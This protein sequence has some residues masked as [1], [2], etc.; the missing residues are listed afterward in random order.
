MLTLM[1]FSRPNS[2]SSHP[3]RVLRHTLQYTPLISEEARPSFLSHVHG[4]HLFSLLNPNPSSP[5][6]FV[7]SQLGSLLNGDITF[8]VPVY[9]VYGP[10]EDVRVLEKFRTG[11]YEVK[12]LMVVDEAVTRLLDIGG[13]KLRLL[14]L[15]GSLQMAKMCK[16]R[17]AERD[18]SCLRNELN[19]ISTVT[20]IS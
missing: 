18:L 10:T 9:A 20:P 16:S 17:L 12:N 14:G 2:W 11:E 7:L 6:S 8:S 1:P 13:V 3:S 5:S 4:P 15:G 19:R